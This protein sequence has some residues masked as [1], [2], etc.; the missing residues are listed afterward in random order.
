[1]PSESDHH[2]I[3]DAGAHDHADARA[4]EHDVEGQQRDRDDTEQRQPIGRIEHEADRRDADQARRRRHGLRQ[5]AEEEAHYFDEHD[6]KAEGDQE[7]VLVRTAVEVTDDDALDEN[8]DDH[9]E[10]RAADH[11]GDVRAGVAVGQPAGVTAEHEHG[12]VREVQHAERAID[13]GEPR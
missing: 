10:Q 9:A 3:L 2:R 7:L 12:A 6:A 13:D 5:A 1:M 11:R 8:A 4:V